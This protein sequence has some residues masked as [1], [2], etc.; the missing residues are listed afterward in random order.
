MISPFYPG[1]SPAQI[2]KSLHSIIFQNKLLLAK[3]DAKRRLIYTIMRLTGNYEELHGMVISPHGNPRCEDSNAKLQ[4]LYRL[5]E[6][7][8]NSF[9]T[10]FDGYLNRKQAF[11][12]IF[13][14]NFGGV[15]PAKGDNK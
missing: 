7:R 9:I 3:S 12:P 8:A 1:I 13:E 11:D 6:G 5:A 4:E 2:H 14:Y 10:S 15:L